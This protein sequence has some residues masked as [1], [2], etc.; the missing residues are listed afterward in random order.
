MVRHTRI[1]VSESDGEAVNGG[2]D[3][4]IFL[5]DSIDWQQ[6]APMRKMREIIYALFVFTNAYKGSRKHTVI[7]LLSSFQ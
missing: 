7:S 6:D 5:F 1:H 3:F 4:Y 2:S